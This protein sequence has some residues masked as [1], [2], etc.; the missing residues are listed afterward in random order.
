MSGW[1][2]IYHHRTQGR[3]VEAVHILNVVREL[4]AKGNHVR[5]VS[6][7]GADP[8]RPEPTA[9]AAPA[10]PSPWRKLAKHAPQ[11]VFELMEM[12]YNLFASRALRGA[13]RDLER[14]DL[15]YER[16]ALFLSAGTKL[17]RKRGVPIVLEVNDSAHV[18]RVRPIL[19]RRIAARIERR[20]FARADALIVITDAFKRILVANGAPADRIHVIHNTAHPDRFHPDVDGTRA[21]EEIGA[22]DL[23]VV[24]FLGKAVPWHGVDTLLQACGT[25]LDD[26]TNLKLLIVGGT[27]GHPDIDRIAGA[28]PL[29]S[30]VHFAG[31][32]PHDDAPAWVA[33]MD[34]AVMP[35][36][37]DFGSPVKLFEYM[38]MK[39]AI[40]A[41]RLG[42]IEEILTDGEHALLV[43]AGDEAALAAAVR[44]LLADAELRARLA[45]AAHDRFHAEFSPE[46]N[47]ARTF[48]VIDAARR[49]V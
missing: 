43:P 21:R 25:L 39:R 10:K 33:A 11:F 40:V 4:E 14:V 47:S 6:P 8:E 37:N 29:R 41:P 18:E 46:R 48:A 42:P 31:Q 22:R 38:A 17:M 26:G 13:M 30:N 49:R 20:T 28:E 35:N 2:V 9:D 1:N 27:A 34:I 5:I 12:A 3:G 23:P 16:Y 7:P 24:G 32:V 44:R 36:S 45:K 15:Y 19:F